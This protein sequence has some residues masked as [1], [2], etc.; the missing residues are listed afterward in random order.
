MLAVLTSA[1]CVDTV[2]LIQVKLMNALYNTTSCMQ[3]KPYNERMVFKP[4][5]VLGSQWGLFS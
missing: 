4:L 1:H 2:H 5:A 3:L